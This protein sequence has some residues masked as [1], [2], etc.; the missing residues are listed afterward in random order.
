[1]GNKQ[2]P[3][4]ITVACNFCRS[5]KLKCDGVRPACGQCLKRSNPCDYMPNKRR[6]SNR[7]RR[8][9]EEGDSDSAEDRSREF[10]EQSLSPTLTDSD[11]R[12][13]ASTLVSEQATV[14]PPERTSGKRRTPA[15]LFL[16]PRALEIRDLVI[17]SFLFLEKYHRTR[18]A[19]A[20]AN[21][22]G[23]YRQAC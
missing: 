8:M 9:G 21:S 18:E 2:R 14:S 10:D 11:A 23:M 12:S 1:M 5:R 20:M 17:L 3:K 7:Q 4:K 19:G 6:A 15:M 22:T 13:L 16:L